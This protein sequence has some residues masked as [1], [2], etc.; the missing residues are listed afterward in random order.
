[1]DTNNYLNKKIASSQ[2]VT[3][4]TLLEKINQLESKLES[5]LTNLSESVALKIKEVKEERIETGE[6][7]TRLEA[8]PKESGVHA[9]RC[10]NL[11]VNGLHQIANRKKWT[12]KKSIN[13]AMLLFIENYEKEEFDD[14]EDLTT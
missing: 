8:I 10:N 6:I 5:K 13:I 2:N 7:E 14:K 1:M 3:M 12:I 11:I 4:E 9:F